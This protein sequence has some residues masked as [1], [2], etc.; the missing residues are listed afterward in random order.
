MYI[1][2]F[3]SQ[4]GV[5][6]NLLEPPPLPTGLGTTYSLQPSHL[7][8]T[9]TFLFMRLFFATA[10]TPFSPS[11]FCGPTSSPNSYSCGFHTHFSS[12]IYEQP[13]GNSKQLHILWQSAKSSG[14]CYSSTVIC[15]WN[16]LYSHY[17][18]QADLRLLIQN[19]HPKKPISHGKGCIYL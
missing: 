8:F 16:L 13:H 10:N 5:R 2:S 14:E 17:D 1:K 11:S 9:T 18:Y 7:S 19:L 12:I 6:A 3:G 15:C 4:M